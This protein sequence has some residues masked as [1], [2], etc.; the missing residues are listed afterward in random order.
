MKGDPRHVSP[1]PQQLGG[2][3]TGPGS[4]R[5]AKSASAAPAAANA[6]PGGRAESIFPLPAST[7]QIKT[8]PS[9][10]TK[11]E[12]PGTAARCSATAGATP[13]GACAPAY[14]PSGEDGDADERRDARSA[15]TAEPAGR[16]AEESLPS[17]GS[18]LPFPVKGT[19]SARDVA[20]DVDAAYARRNALSAP[21]ADPFDREGKGYLPPA[22]AS[23]PSP[24]KGTG[25]HGIDACHDATAGVAQF[26]TPG[27]V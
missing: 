4:T 26:S 23:L 15:R 19:W 16:E 21:A 9:P 5:G 8:S 3:A 12:S 1:P 17:A 27:Q 24:A 25:S 20:D 6:Q 10:R 22:G 13:E 18:S 2:T 7:T 11:T 14:D